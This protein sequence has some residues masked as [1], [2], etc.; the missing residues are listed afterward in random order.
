MHKYYLKEFGEKTIKVGNV[1]KNIDECTTK[2]LFD[3]LP[4]HI[5]YSN[6]KQVNFIVKILNERK[7]ELVDKSDK[8][9]GIKMFDDKDLEYFAKCEYKLVWS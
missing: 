9:D 6:Y 4:P 1:E 7:N 8:R 2:E 5:Q 3:E